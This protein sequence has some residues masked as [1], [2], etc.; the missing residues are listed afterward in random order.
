MSKKQLN[1]NSISNELAGGASLFFSKPS[2]TPLPIGKL[3]KTRQKTKIPAKAVR[4][5]QIP[6]QRI[7]G[8]SLPHKE[9][10]EVNHN[11]TTSPLREVNLR[12][13]KDAIENTET[14]NSSLRL[15]NEEN[16]AIEDMINELKRSLKIKTSLNEVARLG[17]LYIIHDFKQNREESLIYK[18]KKS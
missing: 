7:E 13:W 6:Q 17:L 4:G 12:V 10:N 1:T 11:V 3:E 2:T 9:M 18:V 14:H 16:Y 5:R 15:T 8:T